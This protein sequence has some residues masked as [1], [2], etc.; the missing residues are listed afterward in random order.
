MTRIRVELDPASSERIERVA[1]ARQ[2]TPGDFLARAGE[3]A[4]HRALLDEAIAR[5]E[6]DPDD[7][8]LS[9]LAAE[10]GLA[11]EEIMEEI[12]RRDRLLAAETGQSVEAVVRSRDRHRPELAEAVFLAGCRHMAE[13][14]RDPDLPRRAE[15]LVA[16]QQTDRQRSTS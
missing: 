10:S 4:A 5:F 7:V 2:Q 15:A 12:W 11:V 14:R 16:A 1:R 13:D 6:R 9:E 3:E 8:G